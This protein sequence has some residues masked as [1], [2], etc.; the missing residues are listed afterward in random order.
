MFVCER[1]RERGK[2]REGERGRERERERV[3]M[4]TLSLRKIS[5]L[6]ELE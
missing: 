4:C 3:F 2:E 1:E 6:L 5:D